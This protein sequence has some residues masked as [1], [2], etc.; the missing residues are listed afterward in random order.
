VA[1]SVVVNVRLSSELAEATRTRAVQ[2]ERT[3]S[4]VIRRALRR[5]L[6]REHEPEQPQEATP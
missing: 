6:A 3:A 5:D 2:E 1:S 4:D